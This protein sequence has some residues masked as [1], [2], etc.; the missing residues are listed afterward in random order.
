MRLVL[1][2]AKSASVK[3]GD[4][5]VAD[6]ASRCLVVLVGHGPEDDERDLLWCADKCVNVKLWDG[7]DAGKPWRASVSD[8]GLDVLLVSQFTLYAQLK[9]R[10]PDFSKAMPPEEAR[11]AF[12]DFVTAVRA[13][14]KGTGRVVTGEFG[15]YMDVSL[16]NDGPVTLTF[17]SREAGVV[18]PVIKGR[19]PQ[20]ASAA[21]GGIR[22]GG[23]GPSGVSALHQQGQHRVRVTISSGPPGA[24][25]PVV[26]RVDPILSTAT[27]GAPV[28]QPGFTRLWKAV[29][30]QGDELWD[31]ADP[32]FH[33]DPDDPTFRIVA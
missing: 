27:P 17:D 13:E 5:V 22:D 26:V 1:Q 31:D 14:Y 16:V 7:P 23:A 21:M 20:Q 18:L 3:V 11:R 28:S 24:A 10:R 12:S 33:G 32:S 29:S 19:K 2:R 15:A 4:A 6:C 25:S 30:S 9:G 8:L